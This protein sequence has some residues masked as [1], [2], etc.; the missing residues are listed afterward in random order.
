MNAPERRMGRRM[1]ILFYN[2]VDYLDDERRGGGV[3]LY[4]RNLLAALDAEGDVEA[5]FLS[6]GISFDL[7]ARRPRWERLRHGPRRERARRFEI[8]NSGVLSPAH[9]SFGNPA[10]IEHTPTEAAFED[11][12]ERTGPYDAVHFNNLEGLPARVLERLKTR[13][14]ETRVIYSLHN[15]YP[16][17]P[18]VNLWHR[19]RENCTDFGGGRKCAICLPHR[20]DERLVRSA[21]AAA[22]ILK[23]WGI[24]PGRWIFDRAFLPVL[25]VSRRLVRISARL[26]RHG[27]KT[28]DTP[29]LPDDMQ[30]RAGGLTS[31]QPHFAVRRKEMVRLINENCD[32]VLCV[33]ARVGTVAARYG[34]SQKLLRTSYIGTNQAE[35]FLETAPRKSLV[36]KDGRLTLGYLGYMRRD[37]GFFF[38]LDA[39]ERL[40]GRIST[41]IRLV[42]AARQGDRETMDRIAA[43]S[44][45]LDGVLY[46][47]GYTHDKL[48]ALLDQVDVGVVPVLWEDNLP[49]VAIEMHAR[50]IPLL[51]SDLGG[52]QEL[53]NCP[54]MVFKAGRATSL[55]ARL[56]AILAGEITPA[57]Y[58]RNAV[59]PV[60]MEAHIAELRAI[61][62]G[63]SQPSSRS[64][65]ARTPAKSRSLRH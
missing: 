14:P 11:F 9:H 37:K 45:H 53:A 48:D 63:G 19:E 5:T 16:V 47:D 8:V 23:K 4:Q 54:E 26:S 52:A 62:A 10:Q 31:L 61:Y 50:H 6:S 44:A 64:S 13:W 21:N 39:L 27:R 65:A 43:L 7:F 24:R 35:K 46:A 12:V 22:F 38:L 49:Q 3:S 33:S 32:R 34:I 41:H 58:W 29:A 36:G 28:P 2:W 57:D 17:C 25:R 40:P 55:Q 56:A 1:K 42:V 18:Q 15:Y 60:S 59:A 51:T 20:H 30:G